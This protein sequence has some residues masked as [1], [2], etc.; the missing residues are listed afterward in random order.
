MGDR[1]TLV[2][3]NPLFGGPA[4]DPEPLDFGPPTQLAPL[5]K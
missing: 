3:F 4:L 1:P 2:S 5:S